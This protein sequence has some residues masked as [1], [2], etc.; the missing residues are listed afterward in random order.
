MAREIKS[1]Q[2]MQLIKNTTDK[3]S[4]DEVAALVT[5]IKQLNKPKKTYSTKSFRI[6]NDLLEWLEIS[7]AAS[8]RSP[9]AQLIAILQAAIDNK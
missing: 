3:L 6:P 4:K 7:A 5:G 1:D 2:L 8:H 9:N